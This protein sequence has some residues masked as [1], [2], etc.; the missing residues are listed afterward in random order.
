MKDKICGIYCIENIVNHKMYIGQSVDANKRLCTH[1]SRL[2]SNS[3]PNI[4]L[5]S[6]YNTYGEEMFLFYIIQE[7]SCDELDELEKEYILKFKSY[8]KDF[9]Y[10]IE[11]GGHN[12]KYK[13]DLSFVCN[14]RKSLSDETKQKISSANKGKTRSE[15]AKKNI[16]DGHI[17]QIVSEETRKKLSDSLKGIKSPRCRAVFCLEL[18]QRFWGATEARNALGIKHI[19]ECCRGLVKSAG[20]HPDTNEPLHW[21]YLEDAIQ[22]GLIT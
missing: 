19:T 13:S 3:H 20:K 7:C 6:S 17:G 5:Q 12:D 14:N 11:L 8:D 1:R 10:N 4:H 21:F 9:G 15:T 2:R 16:R 22:L 18:N